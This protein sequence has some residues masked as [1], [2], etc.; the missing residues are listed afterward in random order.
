M[1][2]CKDPGHRRFVIGQTLE[3]RAELEDFVREKF[4]DLDAAD[5]QADM[6][7][8]LSDSRL[9]SNAEERSA[10]ISQA[11]FHAGVINAAAVAAIF[12]SSLYPHPYAVLVAVLAVMPLLAVGFVVASHGAVSLYAAK[13]SVRPGV[14]LAVVLPAA[15]LALRSLKDW[16]ILG[17]SG[18]WVPFAVMSGI[19]VATLWLGSMSDAHSSLAKVLGLSIALLAESYG[20]VTFVNCYFDNSVP[21]IHATQVVSRRI[22]QGKSTAYYVTVGPWLH[23]RRSS[24]I[25][26]DRSFYESHSEGSTVLIG[27]RKGV[28]RMPWFFAQ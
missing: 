12:W 6:A 18:F 1:I 4:G 11:K 5:K 19:L 20:L 3:R 17:L 7:E 26:V 10:S 21:D 28:L 25:L 8:A 9:G 24:E 16:H 27:V 13:N 23:G 22:R 2:V 14:T 15:G